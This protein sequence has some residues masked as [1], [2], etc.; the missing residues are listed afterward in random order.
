MGKVEGSHVHFPLRSDL[1]LLLRSEGH[2]GNPDSRLGW[3]MLGWTGWSLGLGSSNSP[4]VCVEPLEE[5]ALSLL[6]GNGPVS[7]GRSEDVGRET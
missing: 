1:F 7:P 4:S 2:S 6:G 3:G 5:A